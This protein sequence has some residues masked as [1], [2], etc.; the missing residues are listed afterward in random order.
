MSVKIN[1]MN[2]RIYPVIILSITLML[3]TSC[4]PEP[5]V[6]S[7]AGSCPFEAANSLQTQSSNPLYRFSIT[8]NDVD[9]IL[10][11]DPD[12]FSGLTYEGRQ[13]KEMPDSRNDEL[14]D[15]STYVFTATFGETEQI[16]IWC[17]SAFGSQAAAEEY[18]RKAG[19]RLGKLPRVQRELLNHV[20]IH[21]GDETAFA[22]TEGRFFILYSDNMD[23]RIANNDLEETVFHESVHASLQSLASLRA[24]WT[25]AQQADENFVTEYGMDLPGLE[26]MP[27]S[28]L[29]CYVAIKYP[30]RLPAEI[31]RWVNDH[32]PNRLQF[33][34]CVYE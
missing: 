32:I 9:F 14:F 8:S 11:D 28:A 19:P 23:E 10:A 20:V 5:T 22:E 34:R 12:D 24:S 17:H 26:D 18:A 25:A 16:E 21:E 31:E 4:E 15:D 27:E 13:R 6:V 29:F 33:F 3:L 30:G 2:K 7:T 1:N